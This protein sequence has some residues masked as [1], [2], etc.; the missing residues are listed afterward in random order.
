MSLCHGGLKAEGHEQPRLFAAVPKIMVVVACSW[1][2][3]PF[4]FGV[5]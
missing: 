5:L 2:G 3:R 1:P 4:N